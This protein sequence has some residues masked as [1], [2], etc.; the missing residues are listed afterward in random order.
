MNT[1]LAQESRTHVGTLEVVQ[2]SVP[3]VVFILPY[4][5][6]PSKQQAAVAQRYIDISISADD[7]ISLP[8][9]LS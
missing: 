8:G 3:V 4:E 7:I 5:R 6:I 9:L 2:Q 1:D